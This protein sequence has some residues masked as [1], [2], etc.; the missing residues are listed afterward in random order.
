M[1][2]LSAMMLAYIPRATAWAPQ[3]LARSYVTS[4]K[5]RLLSLRAKGKYDGPWDA[6][7][8]RQTF[9]DYFAQK[10]GFEHTGHP[11]SPV[12]PFDD[13][14]LLFANA[15]MNQF[16]PIFLGQA[17]PASPL[18]TLKR[19]VNSQKCIRA[20]GKH[21]DLDDVGKA[22]FFNLVAEQWPLG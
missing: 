17:D 3:Q 4:P 21:N 12:V 13:P 18:A 5:R 6:K 22:S 7:T 2:I 1:Y 11:S 9:Q 20:G 19:A 16:K 8:V 14:T 10:P 15:G